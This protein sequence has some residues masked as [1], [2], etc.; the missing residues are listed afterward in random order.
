MAGLFNFFRG[1]L[2][3]Q[4]NRLFSRVLGSS[5]VRVLVGSSVIYNFSDPEPPQLANPIQLPH[6]EKLSPDFLIRHA[7]GLSA[8]QVLM[9][10]A[11]FC[12]YAADK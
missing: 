1:P 11:I 10:H 6:L 12:R 7:S 2:S 5:T 4:A 3:V 9:L 8:D